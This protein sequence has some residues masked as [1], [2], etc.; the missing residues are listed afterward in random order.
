[1]APDTT[2]LTA[3]EL[4]SDPPRL[5][6]LPRCCRRGPTTTRRSTTGSGEQILR[7]DWLAGRPRGGG[8]RARQLFLTEIDGEQLLVVRG[9]DD[10]L[11]AFHNVC[12]HRGTAVART[13]CGKAVRFQCP[14]HAW[15]YDLD[16]SLVRAKH[17][18]D[19][20]DFSLDEFGLVA[21]RLRDLAGLR[22]PL[23]RSRRGRPLAGPARRPRRRTWPAS[24]SAG[25]RSA[26]AD[27]LR[28]RRQLEVH[29]RE[30]Q[31][32]LPLPGR[33]SRSSTSS[34]RTTSA[35][36]STP[37]GAWQGGWMELV[38]GRRD[39]GHRR[40]P[41]RRPAADARGSPPIDE[42]R[43]Y[44]YVLW[45]RRS[46]RSTPTTCSS[47]G[48]P[49]RRRRHARCVCEWLFEPA[50]I[51]APR[52][53]PVGRRRVLG[54]DQPPGLAR[55]RAA[56]AR[57]AIAHAGSPAATRTRSRRSTRST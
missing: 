38:D 53:R 29:R 1:M 52:L 11:R 45:P 50:T 2:I 14:Y 44:Y 35:A 39:D 51:A 41:P 42:R 19:L 3:E 56:A 32:V 18:E 15:I 33:P 47:T 54:P 28:G 40:R 8:P 20:D 37:N 21:V 26:Q 25:L 17:T 30:L 10:V 34:R 48:W 13:Q 57:D 43:I 31:R 46:C 23:P 9:R 36:T 16:G 55:L 22:V 12:R 7:R 49:D 27:R 6:Q 4:A 24:T 5:S